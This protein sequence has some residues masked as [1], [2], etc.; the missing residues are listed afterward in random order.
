MKLVG[1]DFRFLLDLEILEEDGIR[2]GAP[3]VNA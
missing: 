3:D 2:V 1:Q